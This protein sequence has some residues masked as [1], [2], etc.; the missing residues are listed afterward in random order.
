M[1]ILYTKLALS[2]VIL[3]VV[4]TSC[5]ASLSTPSINDAPESDPEVEIEVPTELNRNVETQS[6]QLPI[7]HDGNHLFPGSG[8]LTAFTPIEVQLEFRPSWLVGI[9]TQQGS[10][11]VAVSE[12]GDIQAITVAAGIVNSIPVV[13]NHLPSGLLPT[14]QFDGQAIRVLASGDPQAAPDSSPISLS[15]SDR[16]AYV[17]QDGD[18]I[19]TDGTVSERLALGVIPDARLLVDEQDRVLFLGRRTDRYPHAVLGDG[20]EAG[21]ILLVD[22][23]P[24]LEL[25]R[26]IQLPEREVFEGISPIWVDVDNDGNREIFVTVSDRD[27]G[28][29]LAVFSEE[30]N[31]LARSP[32]IGRAYRWRH[33]IAVGDFLGDG[34]FE[35]AA[36]LTPHIGGVL[37]FFTWETGQLESIANVSGVSSHRIGSRNLDM[38]LTADIDGDQRLELVV[39]NPSFDVLFGFQLEGDEVFLDWEVP[40]GGLLSTNL[41][42]VGFENGQLGLGLGLDNGIVRLW[43]PD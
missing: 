7:Y 21:S 41:A 42:A 16:L 30:G 5:S 27:E 32:A 24:S 35:L 19:V 31:L 14:L 40:L 10:A 1:N 6:F 39:P 36:V 28:A 4:L 38:A 3:S 9:E 15:G 11:W 26:E 18:F 12:S 22:T 43:L 23:Q 17:D 20:Y 34:Q 37:E 29:Y 33:Q 2:S 8:V 13:P 25:I